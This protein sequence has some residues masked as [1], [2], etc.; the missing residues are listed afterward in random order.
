MTSILTPLSNLRMTAKYLN[1]CTYIQQCDTCWFLYA[2][3]IPEVSEETVSTLPPEMLEKSFCLKDS[4]K[5][6]IPKALFIQ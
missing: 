6:S 2:I 1:L 4:G 5:D 3:F